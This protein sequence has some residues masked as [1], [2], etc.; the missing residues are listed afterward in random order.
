MTRL[1]RLG[2]VV[3][4]AFLGVASGAPAASA[5]EQVLRIYNWS[6][7][8]GATTLEDFTKATGI[9]V[10][11]DTYSGNEEMEAK[12]TA[13]RTPYDIV[14]PTATPYFARLAQG[15]YLRPLDKT[16]IPNL[17]RLDSKLMAAVQNAD[18]GNK[19]GI[20]YAWG[21]NGIGYNPTLIRQR[22][23]NA[24]LQSW[25]MIFNPDV[26]K[27]FADCGVTILNSGYEV[28]PIVLSYLGR[29]PHSEK[30][31]DLR[32]A[33][34]AL[35][36]I[37]PYLRRFDSSGYIED[38]AEGRLCL[39]LG[40]SGDVM[41]AKARADQARKGVEVQYTMPREGTSMWFDMMG[42]LRDAP[43]PDAAYAFINFILEPA[44]MAGITNTVAYANAVPSSLV[45]VK[46][47]VKSDTNIFPTEAQ[48]KKL[49]MSRQPPPAYDKLRQRAWERVT[50]R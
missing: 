5:K 9:K 32:A 41:Q 46:P 23:P 27:K 24:P 47:D 28:F 35:L 6:D 42:V 22:L 36:K 40:W 30:P 26:V 33:E 13:G 25:D 12:I 8:I 38:L 20:I 16:K 39:V 31:E 2:C 43:N 7:Y 4:L 29:E 11:Y 18:P 45:R 49:F 19:Y 1:S 50:G 10:V 48:Q 34:D 15:G 3:L 14:V 37:K 21:T 44:N 17:S